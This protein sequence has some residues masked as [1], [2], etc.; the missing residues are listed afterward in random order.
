M[1][2]TASLEYSLLIDTHHSFQP[3]FLPA[4]VTTTFCFTQLITVPI[5]CIHHNLGR[6]LSG[7][8]LCNLLDECG[9]RLF[10]LKSSARA[11]V[12]AP[13]STRDFLW[14][15]YR[16]RRARASTVSCSCLR[17]S[18]SSRMQT[19]VPRLANDTEAKSYEDR[20]GL[21]HAVKA[22]HQKHRRKLE[23]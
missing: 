16:G 7:R 12:P 19:T 2:K 5:T 13:F 22:V 10:A 21:M 23:L 18:G 15:W 8:N 11:T 3:A 9:F 17:R 6:N 14:S 4:S 1:L 20:T